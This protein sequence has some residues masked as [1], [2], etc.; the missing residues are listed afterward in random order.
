MTVV[1]GK[2][3]GESVLFET[4]RGNFPAES[5]RGESVQE[6]SVRGKVSRG[7][8]PFPDVRTLELLLLLVEEPRT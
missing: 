6:E 2:L 8:C 1:V 3:S 7:S 4:W 5:V